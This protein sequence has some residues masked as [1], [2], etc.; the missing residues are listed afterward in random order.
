MPAAWAAGLFPT[1]DF[2]MNISALFRR[3]LAALLLLSACDNDSTT[4]VT[5][6]TQTTT[7][8]KPRGPR[9]MW[10]PQM[11]DSMLVVIEQLKSLSPEPIEGL[12]PPVARLQPGLADAA[13]GVAVENNIPMPVYPL[14]IRTIGIPVSG[15][16]INARVYT[17][18][19]GSG[20]FPLVLFYQGGGWVIANLNT[21]DNSARGLAAQTG[22]V[23]VSVEYRKGP[24]N[25][26]PT[27]HND[28]FQAYKWV[29]A[30][31]SSLNID[32]ARVGVAGESAGGNLA[33]NVSIMARDSGV[34]RPK[35]QV[36]VYPVAN[37]DLNAPSMLKYRDA[38][39]LNRAMVEWFLFHYLNNMSESADPRIKLV[40]ANL[41]S[42]PPTTIINAG[43]DP[44]LDDGA[45]L[46]TAL[47][48]A[49]V[50]VTRTMYEGVTHEFFG[51]ALVIAEAAKAQAQASAVLKAAL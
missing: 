47:Q 44:L 27:A 31:A 4:S 19:T 29:L 6:T 28:A 35:H 13:N 15:A 36:L 3:A 26:F 40:A 5:P 30:N 42:L 17:P 16:T 49:G 8:L 32:P 7:G 2:L 24:E 33:C 10:G 9:P 41:S 39:P 11:T 23:V 38:K 25:K 48:S 20:P 1:P 51:Q 22:A 18:T 34:T 12:T 21:Y 43:I 50:T 37:N 46:Q 45:A 14:A